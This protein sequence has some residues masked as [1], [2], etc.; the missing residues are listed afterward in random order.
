MPTLRFHAIT[1]D[2]FFDISESLLRDL[3]TIYQVPEDYITFELIRSDFIQGG[4]LQEGFPLV[5]VVAFRRDNH[6]QDAVA[7]SV[8]QH[9]LKAGYPESELYFTYPEPRSYYGN[10]DHY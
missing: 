5:E 7:K 1:T 6:I 2:R 3:T 8:H 10:G 9:L 4:K